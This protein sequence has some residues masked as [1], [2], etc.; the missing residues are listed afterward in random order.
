M[1]EKFLGEYDLKARVAPGLILALPI[2]IDAFYAAPLLSS[3]PIFAASGICSFALIYGLGY[4]ARARG[5]AIEPK[6]W[7]R[8]EGPPS[9]RF[10]RQLDSSFTSEL[11]VS[12]RSAL[13]Q[14]FSLVLPT[15]EE[16]RQ[17]PGHADRAI[18]DAFRQVRQYLRQRD[19]NGLWFKHDIEYGFS[20]N[21]LGCRGLWV[22]VA[23]AATLFAAVRGARPR[24]FGTINPGSAL[25]LLSLT[26]ALYF[27]W[28]VLPDGTRRIADVYA[29]SAWM[30]FLGLARDA[31]CK[32]D[33]EHY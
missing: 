18:H 10:L 21:L 30:A 5:E 7:K 32:A 1:M 20:R 26:C 27:G 25:S 8:W 3:L 2:L 19:P 6:L 12:I 14:C 33:E 13:F 11:K 16:E 23:T 24:I 28:A 17:E 29:E 15:V 31:K 9:T 4:L 22:I